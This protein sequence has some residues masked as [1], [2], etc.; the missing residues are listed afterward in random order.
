[1]TRVEMERWEI[2]SVEGKGRRGERREAKEQL[3][4]YSINFILYSNLYSIKGG[5]IEG[6]LKYY[7]HIIDIQR[8]T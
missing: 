3:Y 8:T 2:E 6:K 1:M 4:Q 7:V 5:A